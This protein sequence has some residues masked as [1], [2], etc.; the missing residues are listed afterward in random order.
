MIRIDEI[1]YNV[2]ASA[3]RQKSAVALHWFDPFGSKDFNDLVAYPD[4]GQGHR[5]LFWDQEPV[6]KDSAKVFFDQFSKVYRTRR[7][8]EWHTTLTLVT[9]ECDS[10]DVQWLQDTYKI[11]NV[12]H[13]FFHGWAAL[14]WYRG[15]NHSYL[16]QL[17]MQRS[18]DKLYI[19]PNNIVSG[20]RQH[21]L[22]LL[23]EFSQRGLI[24]DGMISFPATCP[25][26]G[27]SVQELMR[28]H[29]LNL[30]TSISLPLIIDTH[31]NHA[32]DSHKIDF[33]DEAMRCFSHV[34]TET[35]YVSDRI[36][37]TEKT[38]K[39]IVLQQP[40]LLI[41]AKH[42]LAY[43][44]RYGFKT[45]DCIWDESYD[46]LDDDKRIS[47]IADICQQI[48]QW[49]PTQMR[50]AQERAWP[51]IKHN[52]EWFYGDFQQVLWK[53]TQQMIEQW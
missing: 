39:P 49:S 22:S 53:E 8:P 25:Y 14:D 16:G 19:C 18:F 13:Y 11:E 46:D 2:F 1:Y 41:S 35:V 50:Q 42:S 43:L 3:M 33:W 30:P 7:R 20:N 6:Y 21:R 44:R 36:H 32:H 26:S 28:N 12:A 15:Y 4:M 40:F 47:A 52:F 34:I 37:L 48:K 31:K 10:K 17:W 5:I 23:H 51:I 27:Q 38:F 24:S 9:S 29:G 45:F